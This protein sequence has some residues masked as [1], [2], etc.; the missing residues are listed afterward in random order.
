VVALDGLATE[1]FVSERSKY[2]AASDDRARRA[3]VFFSGFPWPESFTLTFEGGRTLA[4]NRMRQK[5][6]SRPRGLQVPSIPDGM[7]YHRIPSFGDPNFEAV[8]RRA[9]AR[10]F[11]RL[12][13]VFSSARTLW[14]Q[15]R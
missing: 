15:G 1:R 7:R 13:R 4:V 5:W 6:T 9:V 3:E 14:R 12:F 8:A 11:R 10:L 2:I